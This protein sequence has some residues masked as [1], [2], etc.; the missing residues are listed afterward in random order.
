MITVEAVD[1][2]IRVPAEL[3]NKIYDTLVNL[4]ARQNGV[5]VV[6]EPEKRPTKEETA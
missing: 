6:R 4:V 3:H 2:K 5:E 1:G